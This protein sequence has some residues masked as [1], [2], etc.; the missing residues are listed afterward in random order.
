MWP[1]SEAEILKTRP[2]YWLKYDSKMSLPDR[3]DQ[4]LKWIDLPRS[5]RPSLMTVYASDVDTAGHSFGPHSPAVDEAISNVDKM[6][7]RLLEG[8][9][10]RKLENVVNLVVVSDHGMTE[11]N[12]K[13]NWIFLDDYID[14]S[15]INVIYQL[16]VSIYPKNPSGKLVYRYLTVVEHLVHQL[17]I[18]Q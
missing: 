15:A 3:A 10:K 13:D 12:G 4:V 6:L 7:S 8:V 5:E 16:L 9:K 18:M 17:L 1:G 14:V 11:S 2:T